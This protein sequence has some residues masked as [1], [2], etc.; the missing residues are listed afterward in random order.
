MMEYIYGPDG[1]VDSIEHPDP[2]PPPVDPVVALVET[3]VE[4]E[5]IAPAEAEGILQQNSIGVPGES[6]VP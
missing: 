6:G 5:V 4:K 2:A 1:L 3:L